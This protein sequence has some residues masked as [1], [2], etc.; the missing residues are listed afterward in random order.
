[1]RGFLLFL[2]LL[3][4]GVSGVYSG[5]L[6]QYYYTAVTVP[7]HGLP[8]FSIIAY[9][10]G[11]EIARYSSDVGRMVPVAP[12]M[13]R[14]DPEYWERNTQRCRGNEAV[15]KHNVKTLMTRFNH[16]GGYHSAQ[17]MYGC[18]LRAEGTIKSYMQLG[19]DGKDFL[20]L[21]TERW[22]YYPLLY[23]A[24]VTA[25]RWNSQELLQWER[26]KNYLE[27]M[28]TDW[29]RKYLE[30]GKEELERRVRPKVKISDQTINGVIKLHC[31]VYR[32]HPRD[33]DVNWQKNGIDV[34]S[35]E[36]KHVFPNSDGTYQIRV[37]VEIPAEDREGHSC[38][39][40]H[41]SLE[42]ILIV[43]WEPQSS[44]NTL[45]IVI[46]VVLG[47]VTAIAAAGFIIWRKRLML[48]APL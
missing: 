48:E 15:S 41:A 10:D 12:W 1:M 25:Q 46:G 22:L 36:A 21:D 30:Y 23:Q 19:Y 7:G 42:E 16:T 47:G 18:E 29:L 13:E 34:P 37:T 6:L 11:I 14:L 9:V 45:W 38:H 8:E 40:D 26:A 24:Q 28:C 35:Y 5:H 31:Q 43:K 2:L 27:S 33:V 4:V 20:A 32:F 17:W 44:S 3:I 39:V